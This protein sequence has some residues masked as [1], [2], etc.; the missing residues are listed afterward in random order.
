MGWCRLSLGC[1]YSRFL[2][3]ATRAAGSARPAAQRAIR[4]HQNR[5][6]NAPQRRP[7]DDRKH[8]KHLNPEM[9]S[10][11]H[12]I[13]LLARDAC[14]NKHSAGR[15]SSDTRDPQAANNS[16][17]VLRTQILCAITEKAA[18]PANKLTMI[19]IAEATKSISSLIPSPL[20]F[21]LQQR[22]CANARNRL[23]ARTAPK[24]KKENR[25]RQDSYSLHEKK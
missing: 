9:R 4:R 5:Q 2:P 19:S 11:I 1:W 25:L 7:K 14:R 21:A 22:F 24:G 8:P 12:S 17:S 18:I 3:E 6:K 23:R 15:L 10:Q 20:T 16:R 13:P